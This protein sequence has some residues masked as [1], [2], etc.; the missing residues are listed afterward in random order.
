[1]KLK[2]SISSSELKSFAEWKE[3][4]RMVRKGQKGIRDTDG[5][6]KFTRLQTRAIAYNIWDD[7]G[8]ECTEYDGDGY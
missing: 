1:M 5:V 8:H 6:V 3:E 2:V 7:L 4:D